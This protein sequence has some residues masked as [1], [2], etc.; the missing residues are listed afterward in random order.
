MDALDQGEHYPVTDE[1]DIPVSDSPAPIEQVQVTFNTE[2][3]FMTVV[4][5]AWTALGGSGEINPAAVK[6]FE[7]C[8]QLWQLQW[9]KAFNEKYAPKAAEVPSEVAA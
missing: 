7:I 8:H 6:V 1:C 4:G 3:D 2:D 5:K 9:N